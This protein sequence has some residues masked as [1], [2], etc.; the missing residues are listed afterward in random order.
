MDGYKGRKAPNVSSYLANLNAIPSA[1][2]LATQQQQEDFSIEDELAQ[3]TNTDFLDFDADG[4]MEQMPDY[5][6]ILEEKARRDNATANHKLSGKAMD[7][8][9][10][11]LYLAT[12]L[13]PSASIVVA[14]KI[15]T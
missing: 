1:H 3:F 7:Y 12:P 10:G 13:H 5:D 4:Y 8:V 9:T 15:Y 2:D 11:M 14:S 6:P